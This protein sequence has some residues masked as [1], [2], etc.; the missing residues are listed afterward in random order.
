MKSKKT[1][2]I[3]LKDAK[4]KTKRAKKARMTITTLVV[5]SAFIGLFLALLP[6][7]Y[8]VSIDGKVVGVVDKKEFVQRA[9]DTVKTQLE[10]QYKTKVELRSEATLKKVRAR[11]KNFITANYLTSYMR[12][13]M[14]FMVEF[15]EFRVD[16][17]KIGIVESKAILDEL[18]IELK[19]EYFKDETK[20]AE[21]AN[22]VTLEPVFAKEKDV[23]KLETL[24][25]KCTDTSKKKVEYEVVQGDTLSGIASKLGITLSK[26]IKYN[27]GITETTPLKIGMK[28]QAE[29][30][31]PVLALKEIKPVEAKKK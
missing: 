24:V 11:K 4:K 13:N 6:N 20:P 25:E 29:V 16:G 1:K 28:L 10:T 17:E 27:T 18:L 7:A 21:F 23:M 26:L 30:D 12:A 15:Y 8:E 3:Y 14:D 19:K 9:E 31:V 5:I 2:T 22:E